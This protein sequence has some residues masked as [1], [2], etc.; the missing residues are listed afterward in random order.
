[1]HFWLSGLGLDPRATPPRQRVIFV[2]KG[3][4]A[5]GGAIRSGANRIA[6]NAAKVLQRL[7][8]TFDVPVDSWVWNGETL[9][10]EV[11][12]LQRYSV[13]IAV[14]DS[15]A[16][17]CTHLPDGASTIYASVWSSLKKSGRPGNNNNMESGTWTWDTR[18]TH[19]AYPVWLNETLP[20]T[21][22]QRDRQYN[23]GM[24]WKHNKGFFLHAGRLALQ[25]NDA[26]LQAQWRMF[27]G[28]E[29]SSAGRFR[30]LTTSR[31]KRL[32]DFARGDGSPRPGPSGIVG[33]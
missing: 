3:G 6:L 28:G 17:S 21:T 19:Y 4:T 24:R 14:C 13:C 2:N 23:Y 22:L 27:G 7:A 26:L 9:D 5:A 33:L 15:T 8:E 32:N 29:D 11:A 25:L 12:M 10:E 16:F 31:L 20:D 18:H 30:R 1:M